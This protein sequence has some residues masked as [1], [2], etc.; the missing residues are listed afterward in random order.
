MF[1]IRSHYPLHDR[2]LLLH[3]ALQPALCLILSRR[4]ASRRPVARA[5]AGEGSWGSSTKQT[6]S[7]SSSSEC[8]RSRTTHS[9]TGPT[10]ITLTAKAA[11]AQLTESAQLMSR[12]G[13]VMR[14]CDLHTYVDVV[15]MECGRLHARAASLPPPPPPPRRLPMAARSDTA[16][17]AMRPLRRPACGRCCSVAAR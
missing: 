1:I 11:R 12:V 17:R 7:S 16:D 2:H 5:Q 4:H 8:N 14:M 13:C 10:Q 15:R 3:S 6:D 9:D